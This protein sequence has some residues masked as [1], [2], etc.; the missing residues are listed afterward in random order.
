MA[1]PTPLHSPEDGQVFTD[2]P[3]TPLGRPN[4]IM[5]APPSSYVD[6]AAPADFRTWPAGF[7]APL[8]P[9]A[10]PESESDSPLVW[11]GDQA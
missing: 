4:V 7:T 5:S 6:T 10:D 9:S 11:E 3:W 1:S 2:Y 8:K